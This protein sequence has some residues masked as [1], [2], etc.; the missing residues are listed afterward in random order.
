MTKNAKFGA[1]WQMK[2]CRTRMPG[3][4]SGAERSA[5]SFGDTT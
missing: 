2:A 4:N 3:G 5:R 1:V